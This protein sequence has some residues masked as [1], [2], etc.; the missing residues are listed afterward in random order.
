MIAPVLAASP[1]NDCGTPWNAMNS[2]TVP[3]TANIKFQ[4]REAAKKGAA[5][6]FN[7]IARSAQNDPV[8]GL[9]AIDNG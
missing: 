4:R 6:R 1:I 9:T 7:L 2:D 5:L 3:A 8:Y